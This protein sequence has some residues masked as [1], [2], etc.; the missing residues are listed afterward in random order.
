MTQSLHGG[1][2]SH[3]LVQVRIFDT[4]FQL[5][6]ILGADKQTAAVAHSLSKYVAELRIPPPRIAILTFRAIL[7]ASWLLRQ[8]VSPTRSLSDGSDQQEILMP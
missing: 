4:L 8:E 6:I 5:W 2:T 3:V 1:E 7:K